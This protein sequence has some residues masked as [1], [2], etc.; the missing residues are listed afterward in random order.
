MLV[1]VYMVLRTVSKVATA[2][3]VYFLHLRKAVL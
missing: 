2:E 1:R 3:C